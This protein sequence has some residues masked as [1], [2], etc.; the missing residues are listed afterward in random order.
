M[1]DESAESLTRVF[2]KIKTERERIKTEFKKEDKV[3]EDQQ[4]L[5]KENLLFFFKEGEITSLTTEAGRVT[6]SIK[7]RYW[8]SDWDEM[9]KFVL[10]HNVPEFFSKSL[11][12][13]NVKEFLEDNPDIVPK[14]LNADSE[15]V[16]SI[17]KPTKKGE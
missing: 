10:E 14:G 12:Q 5:I 7:T 17:Y 4:K 15:F 8:T 9:Y 6:R 3:L 16:L 13:S 11:N 1:A 2:H